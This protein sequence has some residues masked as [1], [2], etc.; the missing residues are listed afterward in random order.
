MAFSCLTVIAAAVIAVICQPVLGAADPAQYGFVPS[1]PGKSCRDIYEMNPASHGKSGY[2]YILTDR[3]LQVY[4]DM[5]LECGGEKGWMRVADI[6]PAVGSCPSGW[7]KITSPVA[8]CRHLDDT[9][10]CCPTVCPTYNVPYSRV[11]G[12]MIGIQKGTPNGFGPGLTQFSIDGPY[13]DGVSITYG[14][15]RKHIWSFAAG[16]SEDRVFNENFPKFTCPCSRHRGALPLPFVHDHYYCESGVKDQT[17]HLFNTYFTGDPL[18]DGSGCSS[19]NNC[20]SAPGLPWFHRQL[21]RTT[22]EDIE[23]RMCTNQPFD[24][25]SVLVKQAQLYVQ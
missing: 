20:C 18:W 10:G 23:I 11:C 5:V 2:Y 22:S 16:Y 1:Q 24:D 25:E 21:P 9:G 14:S 13:L 6:N 17:T 3:L 19:G 4:C 15:P 8:A 12:M 7:R